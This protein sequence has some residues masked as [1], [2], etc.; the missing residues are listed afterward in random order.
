[1]TPKSSFRNRGISAVLWETRVDLEKEGVM[2]R[3][4]KY[5]KTEDQ[6]KQMFY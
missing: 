2:A 3:D 1:M 5:R 6:L 4:F